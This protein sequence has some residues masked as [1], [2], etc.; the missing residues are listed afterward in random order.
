M[1]KNKIELMTM[2]GPDGKTKQ[3]WLPKGTRSVDMDNV[4]ARDE[5]VIAELALHGRH[6]RKW[7]KRRNLTSTIKRLKARGFIVPVRNGSNY[8]YDLSSFGYLYVSI[9][10]KGI[11]DMDINDNPRDGDKTYGVFCPPPNK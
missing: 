3:Y 9:F 6:S 8:M 7:F 2:Q 11:K 4:S 10:L 5:Q 1:G